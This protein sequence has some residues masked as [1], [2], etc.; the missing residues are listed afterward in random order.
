MANMNTLNAMA[1]VRLYLGL[2]ISVET[3]PISHNRPNLG[4]GGDFPILT[5][6]SLSKR[7]SIFDSSI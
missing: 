6:T 7:R 3:A 5:G 1:I 4:W 2:Y